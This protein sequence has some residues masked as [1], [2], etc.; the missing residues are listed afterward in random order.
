ME[1]GS[2]VWLQWL[3]DREICRDQDFRSGYDENLSGIGTVGVRRRV[4]VRE[5]RNGFN[6]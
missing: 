5:R 1:I 4:S 2:A 3:E 6:D